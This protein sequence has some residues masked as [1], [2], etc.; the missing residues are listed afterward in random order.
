MIIKNAK[1][2]TENNVFEN[3]DIYIENDKFS[4]SAS[5][6][7]DTI[8]ASGLLAIP[9]LVDIHFHGCM[10]H[11]FCDGTTEAF[12]AIAAYELK[13]GVTSICPAT[14][15]LAEDTLFDIFKAAGNYKKEKGE[16]LCGINMEG[17][18]VSMAKK[19]AQNGAYIHKPDVDMFRKCQELSGGLIKLVAI[20]PEEDKDFD[21]I[22][23][24]K[25][26][27]VL[28]IAHTTSDYD[29]AMKAFEAGADHVTHLYNAMPAFTHRAPGVIGAACDT[30]KA[31]VE[32]IC[33]GVHI[34]PAV[35]R[36]T[37]K[38]FGDD[39]ICMISDSM[40]ATGMEDGQYSLGGQAVTV[41]GNKAT[42]ADGTI[43]GSATNLMDCARVAVKEMKLP[44]ESVLKCV[45]INPA[46]SVGLDGEYGSISAGKYA[47]VVL[48]DSDMNIQKIILKGK[49]VE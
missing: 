39:R 1:V 7:G 25:D 14:M 13:N 27:V 17:P 21:F 41:V 26:E 34:H 6:D 31:Y 33:D 20:A 9:G 38:M 15:T 29:T 5:Q 24:L 8:D 2:F 12:D 36:T 35:V 11:D 44:L 22:S 43:A 23:S 40:M 4:S 28:S 18:Y 3:Q 16:T 19:G 32:L 42:L 49:V 47:N 46:K 10:G 45:T 48:M 30:E 37:F